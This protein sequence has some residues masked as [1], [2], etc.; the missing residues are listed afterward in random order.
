LLV[1]AP[2]NLQIARRR[3]PGDCLVFFWPFVSGTLGLYGLLWWDFLVTFWVLFLVTFWAFVLGDFWTFVGLRKLW[4]HY[5]VGRFS[6]D[7]G[8]KTEIVR[9]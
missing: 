5:K 4:R 2:L 1:G 9:E 6:V 3:I 7:L 8:P